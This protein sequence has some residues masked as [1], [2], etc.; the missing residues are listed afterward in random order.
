MR[1]TVQRGSNI[2]RNK[3]VSPLVSPETSILEGYGEAGPIY[4]MTI[5]PELVRVYVSAG[6]MN[7]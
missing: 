6:I 1:E 5:S 2:A 7:V 3:F 4:G